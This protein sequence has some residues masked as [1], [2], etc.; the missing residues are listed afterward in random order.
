[1]WTEQRS[2]RCLCGSLPHLQGTHWVLVLWPE[3]RS[4]DA[5]VISSH[6]PIVYMQCT[7]HLV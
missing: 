2:L 1:M 7:N 3:Q 5:H 4:S 6:T